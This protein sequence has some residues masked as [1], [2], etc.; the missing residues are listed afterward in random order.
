MS[1]LEGHR[2]ENYQ[3]K[4]TLFAFLKTWQQYSKFTLIGEPP[5]SN[6]DVSIVD[7]HIIL[8]S[9][10]KKKIQIKKT[11]DSSLVKTVVKGFISDYLLNDDVDCELWF[12]DCYADE[13]PPVIKELEK[14]KDK[15]IHR[16]KDGGIRGKIKDKNIKIHI[17]KEVGSFKIDGED[18]IISDFGL[19][20]DKSANIMES[21][22]ASVYGIEQPGILSNLKT[23]LDDTVEYRKYKLVKS[24]GE[25]GNSKI[26]LLQPDNKFF[27]KII[28][29]KIHRYNISKE[30]ER[31]LPKELSIKSKEILRGYLCTYFSDQMGKEIYPHKIEQQIVEASKE[32]SAQQKNYC[33]VRWESDMSGEDMYL[34]LLE[35]AG[36][37]KFGAE[38]LHG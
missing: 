19:L 15:T 12:S 34:T 4:C 35:S 18:I 11:I 22:I 38:V 25:S 17:D 24:L 30:I 16:I 5:R 31:M 26:T 8:P 7:I 29:T 9:S 14:A 2:G 21:K 28:L 36:D 32:F 10:V 33:E 27:D 37:Y 20:E 13:T 3:T 23:I 6:E 1:G